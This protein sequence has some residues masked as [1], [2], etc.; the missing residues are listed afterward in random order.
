MTAD[1]SNRLLWVAGFDDAAMDGCEGGSFNLYAAALMSAKQN[2][3]RALMPVL[4]LAG[5][6]S[7]RCN[8]SAFAAWATGQGAIVINVPRISFDDSLLLHHRPKLERAASCLGW[9]AGPRLPLL[10]ARKAPRQLTICRHG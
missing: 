3:A 6:F 8:H 7:R 1:Q 2:A 5:G 10:S 9:T 4:L